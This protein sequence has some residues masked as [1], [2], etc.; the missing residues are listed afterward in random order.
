MHLTNKNTYFERG[1]MKKH[2]YLIGIFSMIFSIIGCSTSNNF[3]SAQT[4]SG[5]GTTSSEILPSGIELSTSSL[6]L[7]VDDT[8]S[9]TATVLPANASNKTIVWNSSNSSVAEVYNGVIY[10]NASG[11][12][13][14]IASTVNNIQT[15]CRLT[16][17]EKVTLNATLGEY[18]NRFASTTSTYRL[19]SISI[20]QITESGD[21]ILVSIHASITGVYDPRGDEIYSIYAK[22]LDKDGNI[23]ANQG[24]IFT[25][26]YLK[27]GQ[28][29]TGVSKNP[30]RSFKKNLAP[31]TITV[32]SYDYTK[33]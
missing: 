17:K 20:N 28:T 19:N 11:N 25:Y 33:A 13:T 30:P 8:F 26:A 1:F 23:I 14:I 2:F 15:I 5:N 7:C 18:T 4:N 16:V 31:L 32:V 24:M 29:Y 22:I 3:E 10:A 27:V 6:T 21:D 12:A 9:L